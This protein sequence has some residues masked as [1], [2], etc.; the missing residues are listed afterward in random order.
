MCG[1]AVGIILGD[2]HLVEYGMD[3]YPV[4]FPE[5]W[6]EGYDEPTYVFCDNPLCSWPGVAEWEEIECVLPIWIEG[7]APLWEEIV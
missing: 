3:E 7:D 4:S 5:N 6:T 1:C 2:E